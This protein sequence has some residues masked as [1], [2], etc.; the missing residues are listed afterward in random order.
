MSTSSA[1][2][3]RLCCIFRFYHD[4]NNIATLNFCRV[5]GLNKAATEWVSVSIFGLGS[6]ESNNFF[7][8]VFFNFKTNSYISSSSTSAMIESNSLSFKSSS[9]DLRSLIVYGIKFLPKFRTIDA[10]SFGPVRSNTF[11]I[12]PH[13]NRRDTL[14]HLFINYQIWN[15]H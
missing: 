7:S 11:F 9:A 12:Q 2:Q 13:K 4:T 1:D 5:N 6:V 14:S 3:S 10:E 15:F 8:F